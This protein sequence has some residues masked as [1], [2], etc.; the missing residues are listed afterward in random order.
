M[1]LTM[2]PTNDLIESYENI[3]GVGCDEPPAGPGDGNSGQACSG[4]SIIEIIHD[5]R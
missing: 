2:V 1:P 4:G 3:L 5:W